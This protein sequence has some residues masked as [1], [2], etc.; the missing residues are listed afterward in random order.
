MP[1]DSIFVSYSRRDADFVTPVVQLLRGT[2]ELVFRDADSIKPGSKW[3]QEIEA[4]LRSSSL[5]LLFWCA[6]SAASPQ[7]RGEYELALA[8]GKDILPVLFDDTPLPDALG[9]YQWVDFRELAAVAHPKRRARRMFVGVSVLALTV[10]LAGTLFLAQRQQLPDT[11]AV[12]T[13]ES[14]PAQPP[15]TA[16]PPSLGAEPFEAPAAD[17][18]PERLPG[19]GAGAARAPAAPRAIT[20]TRPFVWGLAAIAVVT[21]GAWMLAS[22]RRRRARRLLATASQRR[23]ATALQSELLRRGDRPRGIATTGA[24]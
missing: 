24:H 20:A 9:A 5:F 3:Q 8:H 19:A 17:S 22:L 7:V 21:I 14:R 12:T 16:A 6:H 15:A 1:N 4:G 2:R 10:S 11:G 23:M 18:M 13:G